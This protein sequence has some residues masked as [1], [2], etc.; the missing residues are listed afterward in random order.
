MK[1]LTEDKI[2]E[3][4]QGN[5]ENLNLEFKESFDFSHTFP[6]ERLIRAIFAMSN[7]RSGGYVVIGIKEGATHIAEFEGVSDAHMSIFRTK[8]EDLK[9]KVEAFSSSYVSYDIGTGVYKENP[10]I[11]ISVN[12]FS[13]QP[14][15]CKRSSESD[16]QLEEGAIYV[17][18]LKDKPSS[19]KLI[20]PSDVQDLIERAVDKHIV[21]LQRRGFKHDSEN[22]KN[23]RLLFEQERNNYKF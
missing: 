6:R 17:R 16:K 1:E 5:S 4:I 11:I 18:T 7:T 10:Y 8:I 21:N 19:V 20:N 9:A 2:L 13:S 3:I 14:V 15:I 22:I 23:S 12:E